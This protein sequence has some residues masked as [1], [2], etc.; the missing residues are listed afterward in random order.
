MIEASY[1]GE[2]EPM[3]SPNPPQDPN[4]GWQQ[5]QPGWS[6]APDG[7][8]AGV[9]PPQ[10]TGA[11]VAAVVIGALGALGGLLNLAVIGTVFDVSPLLGVLVL[12][13]L[14]VALAVLAGGIQ[15]LRGG[16][17]KLLLTALYASI[18]LNLLV[19]VLSLVDGSFQF[20]NLLGFLI[21]LVIVFLLRQPPAQQYLAGRR[22]A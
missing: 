2:S 5:P 19:V 4:A 11:A 13:S 1:P 22:A 7:P 9:R 14:V 8:T 3:T 6:P 15:L 12:V 20:F 17:E 18:A 21:P 16:D 10:V